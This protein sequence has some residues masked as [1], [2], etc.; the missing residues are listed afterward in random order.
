MNDKIKAA[1]ISAI[2]P[3]WWGH[4][5]FDNLISHIDPEVASDLVKMADQVA[6]DLNL[7]LPVLNL[8]VSHGSTWACFDRH[9]DEAD[10][11]DMSSDF[12]LYTLMYTSGPSH[13]VKLE[14][15]TID[16]GVGA[17]LQGCYINNKEI[18][19]PASFA[20]FAAAVA[21]AI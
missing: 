14:L 1:I 8:K 20:D 12:D 18:Q 16:S 13:K 10:K 9:D 4:A 19:I 2:N 3:K 5:Q 15:T 21:K 17:L 7:T 6:S 11:Y